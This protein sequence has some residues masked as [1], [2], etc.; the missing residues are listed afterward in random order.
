MNKK[1]LIVDIKKRAKEIMKLVLDDLKDDTVKEL[2][3]LREWI[4]KEIKKIKEDSE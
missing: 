1:E 2:T 3:E 4:K